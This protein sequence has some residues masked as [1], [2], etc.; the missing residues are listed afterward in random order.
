MAQE[1]GL[2]RGD[3]PQAP[4]SPRSPESQSP[5]GPPATPAQPRRTRI[6]WW[7]IGI[8]LAVLALNYWAG[9]RATGDEPRLSVPVQPLLPRAGAGGKRRRDHVRRNDDPGS[10]QTP[11][12]LRRFEAGEGVRDRDPRLREHRR[13]RA[14]PREHR[15]GRQCRA[16][17][18]GPAL[19]AGPAHRLRADTPP[20]RTPRLLLA[21]RGRRPGRSRGIRPLARPPLRALRRQG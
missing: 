1:E 5:P 19:V 20:R 4:V 11:R 2:N 9:T 7:W 3:K 18:Y 21:P 15:G 12:T 17:R 13:A 6:R 16:S 8:A 10:L 14:L